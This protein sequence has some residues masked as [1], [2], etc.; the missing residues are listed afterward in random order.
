MSWLKKSL[1]PIPGGNSPKGGGKK[2][3]PPSKGKGGA[4]KQLPPSKKTALPA[5]AIV[6][7]TV[8][9]AAGIVSLQAHNPGRGFSVLL[10]LALLY[11]GGR[12]A[13]SLLTRRTS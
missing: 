13:T 8:L 2:S 10:A 11:G 4:K 12:Y 6:A 9:A 1:P 3:I 7:G 5:L